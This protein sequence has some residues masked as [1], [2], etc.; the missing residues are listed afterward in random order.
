MTSIA[1]QWVFTCPYPI[2]GLGSMTFC[3]M[4]GLLKTTIL[5]RLQRLE[6][7]EIWGCSVGIL[8]CI[9]YQKVGPLS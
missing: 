7:K 5:E 6:R 1:F 9:E 4:T 8:P 3:M 2:N